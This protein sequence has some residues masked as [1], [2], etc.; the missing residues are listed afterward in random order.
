MSRKRKKPTGYRT[1]ASGGTSRPAPAQ[2]TAGT[3]RPPLPG[4]LGWL[5][6]PSSDSGWPSIGRALGRGFITV[7]SSA[8]VLLSSFVLLLALWLAL[9]VLGLEGP[10]ARLV[11]LLALPPISTYFDAL[12]GVTIYG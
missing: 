4:V 8:L 1:P 12:N 9:V 7:G 10:P 6:R 5:S 11:N 2:A 3:E